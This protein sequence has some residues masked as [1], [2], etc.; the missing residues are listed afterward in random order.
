MEG[1]S[2]LPSVL[3]Q[4]EAMAETGDGLQL[5]DSE[6]QEVWRTIKAE[7]KRA[8]A[9]AVKLD[10]LRRTWRS[11]SVSS[12][13]QVS[14][15]LDALEAADGD[16]EQHMGTGAQWQAIAQREKKRADDWKLLAELL[17]AA[18]L[19]ANATA[20]KSDPVFAACLFCHE[21]HE[22]VP[23]KDCPLLVGQE[24]VKEEKAI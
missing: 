3:E 18:M 23:A 1:R 6:V 17:I 10:E 12:S 16:D 7:R 4:L 24:A 21:L 15:V 22:L 8:D 13:L 19:E 14:H 9:L 5:W 20:Q 11:F 2:D